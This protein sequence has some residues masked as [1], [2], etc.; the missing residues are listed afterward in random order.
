V[1]EPVKGYRADN[2]APL[3]AEKDDG[4]VVDLRFEVLSG[5]GARVVAALTAAGYSTAAVL[6]GGLGDTFDTVALNAPET[7]A[8]AVR[9]IVRAQSPSATER[10]PPT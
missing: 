3:P 9:S 8:E 5:Q 1:A 10:H 2:Q 4:P 6:P 7:H